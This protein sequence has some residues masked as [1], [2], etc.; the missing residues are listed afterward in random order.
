LSFDLETARRELTTAV[1]AAKETQEEFKSYKVRAHTVL[2]QKEEEPKEPAGAAAESNPEIAA[3][4][5]KV[6]ELTKQVDD[7]TA[8]LEQTGKAC[9]EAE[10]ENEEL[11][12][13]LEAVTKEVARVTSTSSLQL[14]QM[15]EAQDILEQEQARATRQIKMDHGMLVRSQKEEIETVT[16]ESAER[17]KAMEEELDGMRIKIR[18]FTASGS[19]VASSL[20]HGN[21]AA[22]ASATALVPGAAAAIAAATAKLPKPPAFPDSSNGAGGGAT[23]G[24]QVDTQQSAMVSDLGRLLST[25]GSGSLSSTSPGGGGVDGGGGARAAAGT[26]TV[27]DLHAAKQQIA[28]LAELLTDSESMIDRLQEQSQVLKGEIRRQENLVARADGANLEYLK[29][30]VLKFITAVDEREQLIPV[31]GMLLHFTQDELKDATKK[32]KV[33]AAM[34]QRQMQGA[35][36][37]PGADG[38]WFGAWT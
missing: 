23:Y 21:G 35:G 16:T 17:L 26:V 22:P 19:A 20:L 33:L 2:K 18:E 29:N 14:S 27:A 37:G 3:L 28:H 6:K 1:A 9:E 5:A 32:F 24:P 38:S 36:T 25:S 10:S 4:Q 7:L 34:Q 13:K 11:A 31:F 12:T 30:V 8:D 15:Q